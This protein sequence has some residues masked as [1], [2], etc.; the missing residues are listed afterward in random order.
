M[1]SLVS[2]LEEAGVQITEI[3]DGLNIQVPELSYRCW[4]SYIRFCDG[5]AIS[6]YGVVI[7]C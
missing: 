4:L 5:Y 2:K 1:S 7:N 3:K 6:N